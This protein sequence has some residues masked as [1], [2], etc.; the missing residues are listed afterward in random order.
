MNNSATLEKMAKM[1]LYGMARAF[2]MSMEPNFKEGLTIDK[3][4]AF[5]IDAEWD[6]RDN[7]KTER[8]IRSAKFRHKA[9][10][11]LVDF[12]LKRTLREDDL[13]RLADVR[14]INKKQNVVLTGPTGVGKSYI[15][16]AVGNKM[17]TLGFKVLYFS[18]SKLFMILKMAKADGTYISKVEKIKKSDLI[19]L[20]DFGL[21]KIQVDQRLSLL[22]IMEDRYGLKS[23]IIVSQ[24][25]TTEW[26]A[27]IGDPTIADAFCDRVLHNA[28]KL[29]IDGD[30]VRKIYAKKLT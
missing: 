10:I 20:D 17:C 7:R 26:H 27:I 19:I 21:E 14:W 1:K 18:T 16:C 23:T 15:A 24:I 6:E 25:P 12:S 9:A 4:V 22:E 5:L 30:S 3:L 28:F 8:L 29:D 13:L 2:E 11:E